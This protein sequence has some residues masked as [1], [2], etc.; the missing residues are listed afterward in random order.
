MHT[1]THTE[2][3]TLGKRCPCSGL[4]GEF[5][6][7]LWVPHTVL[8]FLGAYRVLQSSLKK[9]KEKR[10]FLAVSSLKTGIVDQTRNFGWLV[11]GRIS[12]T[13]GSPLLETSA[14]AGFP[15][16]KDAF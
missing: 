1:D 16:C 3:C 8:P 13:L 9:T 4:S 15:E 12:E 2:P 11:K 14:G 6:P 7:G 5:P 10:H